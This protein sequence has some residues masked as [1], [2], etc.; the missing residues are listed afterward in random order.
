[1]LAE[2]ASA[3]LLTPAPH[4]AVLADSTS[5]ALLALALPSAVLAYLA[6]P[7]LSAR[8]PPSAVLADPASAAILALALLAVVQA[9]DVPVTVPPHF[10]AAA[11]GVAAAAAI[12]VAGTSASAAPAV[13]AA[14]WVLRQPVD[15]ILLLPGLRQSRLRAELLQIRD[16]LRTDARVPHEASQPRGKDNMQS[17]GWPRERDCGA[18]AAGHRA[19]VQ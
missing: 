5:A 2:P 3:A 9:E 1:M 7:A 17:H 16:G 8:A 14:T 19:L 11:L 6:A 10:T 18:L 15:Q 13:E 12:V 4:A